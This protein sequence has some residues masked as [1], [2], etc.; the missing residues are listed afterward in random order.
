MG[1]EK[2]YRT[3]A[4]FRLR[5]LE[6]DRAIAPEEWRD[7]MIATAG[8]VS[9]YLSPEAADAVWKRVQNAPCHAALDED[10]RQW[11]ALFRAIGQRDLESTSAIAE[12]LLAARPKLALGEFEYLY[13]A[14]MTALIALD[15]T[16][17]ARALLQRNHALL[18]QARQNL[19]W[20]RWMRSAVVDVTA[21]P[22]AAR[23]P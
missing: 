14:A 21:A 4:V 17:E 5:F 10:T 18:P 13:G 12:R 11:I 1:L 6:C 15:R 23:S 20:F 22:A 19:G 9:V 16:D 8:L 3:L 7:E 2:Y